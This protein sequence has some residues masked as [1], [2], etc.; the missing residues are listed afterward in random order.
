MKLNPYLKMILV[1]RNPID[2]AYSEW[3]MF[4]QET[5]YV[6]NTGNFKSFEES[7]NDELNLRELFF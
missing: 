1:L 7:I 5:K 4:N 2:R 3:H 6:K